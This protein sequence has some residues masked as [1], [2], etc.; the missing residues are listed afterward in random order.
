MTAEAAIAAATTVTVDR[1]AT[2]AMVRDLPVSLLP[3]KEVTHNV[4]AEKSEVP[5]SA[6]RSYDR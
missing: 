1:A 3:K 5:Q 4:D 6:S 2:T